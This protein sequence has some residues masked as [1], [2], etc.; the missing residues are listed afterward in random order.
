MKNT[1]AGAL[2]L[3]ASFAA[4]AQTKLD[5][6]NQSR[7]VDLSQAV[8]V[9]PFPTGP[10][11][12]ATCSVGQMFFLTVGPVGS[13]QCVAT[14][15]WAPIQGTSG[16]PGGANPTGMIDVQQTTATLLTIGSACSISAPCP[17]RIG[18]TV[19]R[20]LAPATATV[21][22]GSGFVYFYIDLNG[23]LT[24]GV[25]SPGN[26]AITCS[27]CL[28]VASTTQFPLGIIPLEIW[29]A[30]NATWDPTGTNNAASLS[31]PP[32]VLGGSNVT[33]A[34]TASNVTISYTGIDGSNTSAAPVGTFN[35]A[36]PTQFYLN[37]FALNSGFSHAGDGWDYS[38]GCG[39]GQGLGIVGFSLESIVSG[40]WANAA[41][42]GTL[43]F[44]YYP[45]DHSNTY[46]SATYDFWSGGTPAKLWLAATYA[47]AD[48]NGTHYVG[49]SNS[50][51]AVTDFIGCRQSGSGNWFAV[52]RAAGADVAT[53]DTG[54]PHDTGT[55]R[56]AVDNNGGTANT[57]RC[58]VDGANTATVTGTVP[59]EAFGW[60]FVMGAA[61][62]GS[63]AVNFGTFQYTIFLQGLP[64]F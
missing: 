22:G 31:V 36:D 54:Y 61:A 14:N 49:L 55:H 7:N 30:T 63:T 12:P 59:G 39:Q 48:V 52:I 29:N 20:L 19:Y 9:R 56:I 27:G 1:Y 28:V 34:Q 25:A 53:A 17:Y 33:V 41:G 38:V 18:S 3:A 60:Y 35:P 26:P 32:V 8:S 45:S 43:C 4:L 40:V 51:S 47:T 23:S 37:H 5:L 50:G 62:T 2:L 57:V 21:T 15:V 10:A 58:S 11:L 16:S 44:F 64:R 42:A 24:A 13:N 46:G 6:G